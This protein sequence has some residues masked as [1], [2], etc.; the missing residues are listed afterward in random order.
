M[1]LSF[2]RAGETELHLSRQIFSGMRLKRMLVFNAHKGRSI[3]KT[4]YFVDALPFLLLHR[5]LN[6]IYE[7]AWF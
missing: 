1:I 5:S 6:W 7:E 4:R 2:L 3:A